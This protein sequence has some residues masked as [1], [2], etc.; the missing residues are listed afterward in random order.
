M[1]DKYPRSAAAFADLRQCVKDSILDGLPADKFITPKSTVTAFGSCFAVNVGEALKARG[2]I[3]QINSVG[4]ALNSPALNRVLVAQALDA[5]KPYLSPAWEAFMP[6]DFLASVGESLRTCDVIIFTLGVSFAGFEKGKVALMTG[7]AG[8]F[9]FI[10]THV[11]FVTVQENISALEFIIGAIRKV[12]PKAVF[13]L[14]VSPVPI[15]RAMGLGPAPMVDCV[16]KST[17]RLAAHS[18]MKDNPKGVYYWPSFEIVRWFGGHTG[19]A[20]G[21]DDGHPRHV[22]NDLVAMIVDLFLE[23]HGALTP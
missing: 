8:D 14:T 3:T 18:I 19:P 5:K 22:N 16:S 9:G 4:E 21:A 1:S 17:L 6:R 7:G 20:Y 12:N 15:N 2:V 23:H 13:V 10:D 11:R